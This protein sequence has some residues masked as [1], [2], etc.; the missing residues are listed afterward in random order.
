MGRRV[1]YLGICDK[2]DDLHLQPLFEELIWVIIEAIG[3][4]YPLSFVLNSIHP[5]SHYVGC[6]L[7]LHLENLFLNTDEGK[8]LVWHG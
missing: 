1:F 3:N 5:V 7:R 2:R 6:V 8:A 4:W